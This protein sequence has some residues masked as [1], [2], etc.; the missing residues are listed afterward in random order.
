[1]K[2]DL[3][4]LFTG[5][6]YTFLPEID[7][8]NTYLSG[9]LG[10]IS[11]P[12]GSVIRA[13]K[14]N[15]GRGQK[16]S[17]WESEGGKNLL[18]SFLF[19]P[20]FLTANDIFLLNKT[21][22]LGVYDFTSMWLKKNVSIK[23][24]NDIYWKNKKIAGLLIENSVNGTSISHSILGVGVNVNQILFSKEL[25]N[26][27]SFSKIKNKEFDLEELFNSLCSCIEIR[28]LQLKSEDHKRII[29]EYR[30]ALFN[31]EKWKTYESGKTRF[32]GRIIDVDES[33][34]LIMEIKN[35]KIKKYD[36]KEIKYTL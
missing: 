3:T 12:E 28:Y 9:I 10:N 21:F 8:T 25:I 26:P 29:D 17:I 1:M 13:V 19:Y 24:P 22:A 6:H 4:T 23:W 30:T 35:G 27:I 18:L 2:K 32:K 20:E 36:L 15:A 33:G 14:Q 7:S 5:R 31:L 11:L 16:G 34:K